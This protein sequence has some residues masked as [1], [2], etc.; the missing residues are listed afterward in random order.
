MRLLRCRYNRDS[1]ATTIDDR[2]S[3]L[4][5]LPRL[6]RLMINVLYYSSGSVPPDRFLLR[7]FTPRR[8]EA[9]SELEPTVS[10]WRPCQS[11]AFRDCKWL[12]KSSSSYVVDNKAVRKGRYSTDLIRRRPAPAHARATNA[13]GRIFTLWSAWNDMHSDEGP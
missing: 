8:D 6:D 7:S 11:T 13:L 1:Q 9:G 12:L 5:H 2:G 3:T 4:Q 10:L